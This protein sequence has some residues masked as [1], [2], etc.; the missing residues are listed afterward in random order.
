M[1]DTHCHL[2]FSRF[3]SKGKS[4]VDEVINAAQEVGVTHIV[5]PGTDVDTSQKAIEIAQKYEHIYAAVGIHPHHV[6]EQV[7]EIDSASRQPHMTREITP[8]IGAPRLEPPISALEDLLTHIK[9]VA[10]GEIGMDRHEYESTKYEN[11][12]VSERFLTAQKELLRMQ[13][14]LGLTHNKSIIFH[15]RE[16]KQDLLPILHELWDEKLRRRAVFHCCE[17]DPALLQFAKEHGMYIGV[18]GDITYTP[19]K[20]AFMTQVPLEMLVLETD[21]P[22]LLPEPLRTEKKFPNK[23]ENIPL[24]AEAVAKYMGVG[25]D[26]VKRVTFENSKKL[27][28][29]E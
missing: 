17:P 24:I 15:N 21:A 25:I 4:T 28:N 16:A 19:E 7:A 10:V 18:D 23:P 20:Q 22:F 9:V 8:R 1:F 29:V 27:F 14:Q 26:E 13:I 2:N 11:Y 3:V 12:Q 6:Y 5:I